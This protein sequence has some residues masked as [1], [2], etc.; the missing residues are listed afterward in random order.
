MK[1]IVSIIIVVLL[2]TSCTDQGGYK[3]YDYTI[4]N[5]TGVVVEIVP[6]DING[7]IEV[8]KKVTIGI[9]EKI[10]RKKRVHPIDGDGPLSFKE[11]L[12]TKAG[13][14]LKRIDFV[15]NKVKKS[16]YS[17]DCIYVNGVSSNCSSRNVFLLDYNDGFTEV[18]TITPEDYQNAQDCGGNCN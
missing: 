2:A 17:D 7:V 11:L 6:Y 3:D 5:N 16:S 18:Y 10:N 8:N 14:S 13:F 12:F 4:I 1:K 15:F 9:G